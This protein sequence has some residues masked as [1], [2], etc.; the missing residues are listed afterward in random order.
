MCEN[1]NPD[2]PRNQALL[3][4]GARMMEGAPGQRKNFAAD[5]GHGVSGGVQAYTGAKMAQA[6]LGEEDQ[7]KQLRQMQMQEMQRASQERTQRSDLAARAF[8]PGQAPMVPGDDEGNAM[9]N[10]GQGG[11]MREYIEG[12]QRI[13]P[14]EAM[15]LQSQMAQMNAKE[16]IKLSPGETVG[17]Y[18]NGQFKADYSAPE[19]QKTPEI[20]KIREI[21]SG[22]KTF[23]YE[24]TGQEW[25]KVGEGPRFKPDAAE[26]PDK[27]PQG[28]RH[29]GD[30]GLTFIPG[31]PADP[32]RPGA[33]TPEHP[34]EDERRSA[35]LTVR[36]ADALKTLRK[37]PGDEKPEIAPSVVRAVTMGRAEP[38]ANYATTTGRQQTEAAQLD[39]L[40]AALTLATGAAYT[41]DQLQN[42]R[43]SYFAQLGDAP[44]TIRD[45]EARFAKIIETARIRAGRASG[46]I[47]A[48][49]NG[50]LKE[51]EGLGDPLGMRNAE[52]D[53][54]KIR[55]R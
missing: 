37:H 49:L 24:W 15:G 18:N 11:G 10:V 14:R 45:K 41:K 54:L 28:Y 25:K 52:D 51:G 33:K 55:R 29:T 40:D 48:V 27:P 20:G 38:V 30:G 50:N 46:S 47:D 9:P 7:Q 32:S 26:K 36:L 6:R 4:M 2:D 8:N 3:M 39:A 35:G 43:K 31:G 5:V 42:L 22:G 16:R 12:M 44:D 23:Q 17:T 19:K 21:M 34:T 1:F 53:P 13:D